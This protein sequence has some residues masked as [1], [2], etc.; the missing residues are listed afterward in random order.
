MDKSK[1]E[2]LL[3]PVPL[4]KSRSREKKVRA[5]FWP[6]FRAFAAHIP[7][8]ED[9][10][11]AYYCATDKK[12]PLKVRGTLLAALAYFILPADIVP[13]FF[14]VVGFSDDLA[15]FT[16]AM[17]LVQAHVTDEHREKARQAM[18]TETN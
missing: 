14:A 10:A 16:A 18:D 5:Q 13:D 2:K 7:F 12:T 17:T 3:L 15:V 8:A 11:A 9:L 1:I 4:A 6:K